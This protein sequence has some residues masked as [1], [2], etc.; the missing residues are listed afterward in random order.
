[1]K[2]KFNEMKWLYIP[3]IIISVVIWGFLSI[4][5]DESSY[6]ENLEYQVQLNKDGSMVVTEIWDVNIYKKGTQYIMFSLE[7]NQQIKDVSV[8]D[9]HTGKYLQNIE[10]Q[11]QNV[12]TGCY[13]ALPR[14]GNK[15]EIA[16]GT[17]MKGKIGNKKYQIQYTITNV[18]TEYKDCQELYWK[19]LDDTNQRPIKNVKM[20]IILPE[21][22][23]D[24]EKLR[25]WGHGPLN[26]NIK[27]TSNNTVEVDVENFP[28]RTML[29]VRIVT[30][31]KMFDNI[32]NTKKYANLDRI[33]YK[34][35]KW[36]EETNVA[37][38]RVKIFFGIVGIIYAGILIREIIKIIN[39]IKYGKRKDDG[40][41]RNE[42]KYFRDI[43]REN[44][45]TPAEVNYLY[46]FEKGKY[47]DY[48]SQSNIVSGTILNLCLKKY[49][50]L[51]TKGNIVQVQ[52]IKLSEG[53]KDD[54]K[55]VYELLEAASKGKEKFEITDLNSYAKEEYNKYSNFIS[56]I[57]NSARNNLYKSNLVDKQQEQ[58]SKKVIDAQA[59]YDLLLVLIQFVILLVGMGSMFFKH[60][61]VKVFG[62]A[63]MEK[64]ISACKWV[65]P[66]IGIKLISLKMLGKLENKIAV[67]TQKGVDE[68]IQLKA[69]AN[70]LKDFSLIE[71]K[72]I[73]SIEIWEKYLVFATT[74]GIAKEVLKQMKAKYPE[75]FVKEYWEQNKENIQSYE[76]IKFA[77]S[78]DINMNCNID[79][80]DIIKT[81]TDTAYTHSIEQIRAHSHSSGS[82][83]WR[84]IFERRRWPVE[85]VAGHGER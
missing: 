55:A 44:E 76:I 8:K 58:V 39:Y 52:I 36:A 7:D 70:Y 80:I 14:Y 83:R 85:V 63:Y 34:E 5:V 51:D 74:M 68:Q 21:P 9:L 4:C 81:N 17:G 33:L 38:N 28:E 26:G 2:E 29:E 66:Y 31:E 50:K 79:P 48:K 20:K 71:E 49:I 69:L 11:M 27:K 72:D 84:R 65:M 22:I 64:F 61:V 56:R 40:I 16:W 6:E 12:T 45:A 57:Y 23:K 77:I 73:P 43:P 3:M 1:M 67:L 10:E 62:I 19:F 41:I 35:S 13:Y 24:T 18:I 37:S 32:A 47:E 15:F 30:Q 78:S 25:V 53:L 46:N 54:E 59:K 42:L 82:G 75:V 60:T